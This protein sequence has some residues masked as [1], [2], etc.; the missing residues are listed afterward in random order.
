MLNCGE[1]YIYVPYGQNLTHIA[2][3][4]I[5]GSP[6]VTPPL[7]KG[8]SFADGFIVGVS[9][10]HSPLTQYSFSYD[11][12]MGSFWLSG[13]FIERR[14]FSSVVLVD[15]RIAWIHR[16]D[17]L[18]WSPLSPDPNSCGRLRFKFR[19]KSKSSKRFGPG[20]AA[21]SDFGSV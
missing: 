2:C 12:K 14:S 19:D 13:S 7:P 11:S 8:L 15:K 5:S 17:T 1:Q 21:S 9:L 3:Y 20:F 16:E 18:H 6:L 10:V 4:N